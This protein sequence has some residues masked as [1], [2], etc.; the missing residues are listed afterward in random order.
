MG[1]LLVLLTPIFIGRDCICEAFF[2]IGRDAETGSARS[3]GGGSSESSFPSGRDPSSSACD[4]NESARS[5]FEGVEPF[6]TGTGARK[7]C[8]K[9]IP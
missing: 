3:V 4:G 6:I 5:D 1:V 2:G 7:E 9:R 8:V